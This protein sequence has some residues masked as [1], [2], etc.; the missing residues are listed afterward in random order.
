M[1]FKFV[2]AFVLA[3]MTGV[4]SA[5]PIPV[6]EASELLIVSNQPIARE[7]NPEP[8]PICSRWACF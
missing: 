4:V 2:A 6:T 8:K 1:Q 5:A 7:A 3:C